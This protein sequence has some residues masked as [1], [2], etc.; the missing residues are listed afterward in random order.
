MD[1]K[2]S[3]NYPV[4]Q[5]N[6]GHRELHIMYNGV[7]HY[8]SAPLIDPELLAEKSHD[9]SVGEALR[10]ESSPTPT[11]QADQEVKH[12]KKFQTL[13]KRPKTSTTLIKMMI[14]KIYS[15]SLRS[16]LLKDRPSSDQNREASNI[17]GLY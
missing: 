8:V 5:E 9:G 11:K 1:L 13:K 15:E 4:F 7:N 2:L 12:G 14:K 10:K 17:E 3:N 16:C 6:P